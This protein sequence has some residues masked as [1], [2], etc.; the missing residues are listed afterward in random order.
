MHDIL[1]YDKMLQ[2]YL[3]DEL[4]VLNAHLP[5]NQKSLAELLREEYPHVVCNDGSTH[6]FKRK[7]LEYLASLIDADMQGALP[8]PIL[9]ELGQNQ[10][11]AAVICV[12]EITEE[13]ISKVLAM[14]IECK[15][16][17]I[18]I[19][20]PQLALLRKKLKTTTQYVFPPRVLE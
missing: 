3:R 15:Q 20:K 14:P 12:G 17:R 4:R 11:E 13:V 5:R 18:T 1:P 2:E 10:A 19:Y 16:K 6:L 8:L 7:E 9:V